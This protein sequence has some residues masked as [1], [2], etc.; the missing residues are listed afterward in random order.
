MLRRWLL[1]AALALG[2]TTVVPL[3]APVAEAASVPAGFTDTEV[4]SFSRP[5][6]VEWLP[7]GRIAVLEQGGRVRTA[8]PGEPFTTSV[9]IP[10]VCSNSERGLLGLTAHPAYFSNGQVFVYTTRDTSGTC[11]N[12]VSRFTMRGGELDLAS[13]TVLLDGI[14]SINGNHNGGDLD[15]GSDGY[16]YVGVGDA[17]RDPRGDSG[18]AGDNDAA[19]D[20]TLLNGKILRLTLNGAPAP[21]NPISGPGSVACGSRGNTASTPTTSCQEIFAWGLRNPYRF[22]FDRNT[23]GDRFFV[24]DVGQRTFEEV[25]AGAPGNFGWP[26]REGPCPQGDTPPCP[27][28]APGLIDPITAYGR[29]LGSYI[30]AG[31]FVPDGRW[32]AAYEGGYLFADGGSGNIWHLRANGTVDYGAPFATGAF[33]ITDMTFG[34]D[35]SG[36][37]VLYYVSVGDGL[38]MIRP[39]TAPAVDPPAAAQ[40]V[41]IVPV[42]A[43]DT[44]RTGSDPAIGTEAGFAVAGTS[45]RIDLDPPVGVSAALVNVTVA[46][47]VG[48]GFAS[49]WATGDRP[50]TSTVNVDRVGGVVANT[51]VVPLAD[52]GTFLLDISTTGR[53]IVDVFA[54][55]RDTG[56]SSDV[57]RFIA[58]DP[59]RLADTREPAGTVLGS[60]STNPYTISG[61][62]PTRDIT[63]D[64]ATDAAGASAVPDDA[65]AA[66]VAVVAISRSGE[67]GYV[68]A[69]PAGQAYTGTSNVN[70]LGGETRANMAVV[71]L[72]SDGRIALRTFEVAA[73]AVD[74]LGY[75]TGD[76]AP[77]SGAGL[78]TGTDTSRL[79]DTRSGPPGRLTDGRTVTVAVPGGVSA[80]AVVHNVTAVRTGGWGFLTLHPGPNVPEVSTVNYTDVGQTRAA[81]A[82]TTLGD[83]GT[84]RVTPFTDTDVLIDVLGTFSE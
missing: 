27:A 19:Q 84:F 14:S 23:G 11:L 74:V 38:R 39:T 69:Y 25:N 5:T 49:T 34:Y 56:G 15:V 35:E 17:G 61:S 47:A 71:P 43:Y 57:G 66:V 64:V 63:I 10:D 29:S 16:L 3:G 62:G 13:E 22:A 30:T 46:G 77:T 37:T 76:T 82:F 24:N 1:P 7:D 54:W 42:R 33:G 41:P 40:L 52:D 12:R 9:Q 26:M 48:P 45:R 67:P 4:A 18:S 53:V 79:V 2:A 20:L 83:D 75:V 81:L 31:A 68:G 60:G 58:T 36:R 65:T 50:D 44:S 55:L 80:S 6:T 32:P 21:G 70:V 51:T 28:P 59:A 8:F 73:V 78:Y 72:G